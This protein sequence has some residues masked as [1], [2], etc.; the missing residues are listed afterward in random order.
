[1]L[2]KL[3]QTKFLFHRL[4]FSPYLEAGVGATMIEV[5]EKTSLKPA[6]QEKVEKK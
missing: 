3:C 4:Y 2:K 5:L 6:Y 1:M